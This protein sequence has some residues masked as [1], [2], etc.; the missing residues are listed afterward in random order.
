MKKRITL[1][2]AAA[3]LAVVGTQAQT[4]VEKSI[5]LSFANDAENGIT[6]NANECTVSE[7][8]LTFTNGNTKKPY[9][10]FSPSIGILGLSYTISSRTAELTFEL[11]DD[12]DKVAYYHWFGTDTGTKS[13]F[14]N[15]DNA[16]GADLSKIKQINIFVVHYTDN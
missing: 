6:W 12:N 14:V 3:L 9:W 13:D 11:V 10:T 7:G 8:T 5:T 15:I 4:T 2:I 1:L 16:A